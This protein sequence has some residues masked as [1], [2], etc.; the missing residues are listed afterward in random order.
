[1]FIE[2]NRIE[3]IKLYMIFWLGMFMMKN[4]LLYVLIITDVVS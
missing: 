1:M 4:L 3:S 2:Q